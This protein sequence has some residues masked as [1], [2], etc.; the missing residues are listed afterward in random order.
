MVITCKNCETRFEIDSG[1]IP[2]RGARVRC[3]RCSHRF[4]VMPPGSAQ[5]PEAR[6]ED[7]APA[8]APQPAAAKPQVSA[9]QDSSPPGSEDP[10]P[11]LENP[12]FLFEHDN[13]G[14]GDEA[15]EAPQG[16]AEAEAFAV[17][18]PLADAEPATPV[19]VA[20]PDPEEDDDEA[21]FGDEDPPSA[22][23]APAGAPAAPA[24][25]APMGGLSADPLDELDSAGGHFGLDA[26]SLDEIEEDLADLPV[27]ASRS[28]APEPAEPEAGAEMLAAFDDTPTALDE[29]VDLPSLRS[30]A[31]AAPAA[32]PVKPAGGLADWDP[33]EEPSDD[34]P[35]ERVA[36][37]PFHAAVDSEREPRDAAP[38]QPRARASALR[39]DSMAMWIRAAAV[40]VGVA[41]LAGG[42]RAAA[43]FGL[44][45]APGPEVVMGAGWLATEIEARQERARNG[46]RVLVVRG[47]LS[48]QGGRVQPLVRVTL[49]DGAGEPL[50]DPVRG[51]NRRIHDTLLAPAALSRQL[52]DGIPLGYSTQRISGFTVL[53]PDP[54]PDAARYLLEILPA[55]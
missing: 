39:A 32:E 18:D 53:V 36:P 11:D 17:A 37:A 34:T 52:R 43:L 28:S 38:A 22:P 41:L 40:V 1:R 19:A 55:N 2:A 8:G 21:F 35:F 54:S 20:E 24:P 31:K 42:V 48:P 50:G 44:G 13:L 33:L 9:P 10:D 4:H 23:L 26:A 47:S 5:D 29:E 12:E 16:A 45:P 27:P 15:G 46:L 7:P 51:V 14:D 3:S 30:T 25:A 6:A 49:L